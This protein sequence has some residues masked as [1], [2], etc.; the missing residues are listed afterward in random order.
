MADAT[1]TN[2]GW[3]PYGSADDSVVWRHPL[4]SALSS[5]DITGVW[6]TLT[7][8]GSGNTPTHDPILGMLC[9]DSAGA[10]A[11]Y[12]FQTIAS[13]LDTAL[14]MGGQISIECQRDL[15]CINDPTNGSSGWTPAA[16]S[17]LLGLVPSTG[18]ACVLGQKNTDGTFKFKMSAAF[19]SNDFTCGY[20]SGEGISAPKIH[21]AGKGA[22]VT[23][24]IGWTPGVAG[25]LLFVA[26]DGLLVAYGL[27]AEATTAKLFENLYIGSN[28]GS[29]GTFIAGAYFRNLQISTRPPVFPVHPRC[30]SIAFIGDSLN[31]DPINQPTPGTPAY[32]CVA[33]AQVMKYFHQRGFITGNRNSSQNPGYTIS[34]NGGSTKL[35]TVLTSFTIGTPGSMLSAVGATP[36]WKPDV[37][38]IVGGTND[39]IANASTYVGSTFT[40]SYTDLIEQIMF[41]AA[42]TTRTPTKMVFCCIPPPNSAMLTD[43]NVQTALPDVIARI[44]ALPAWWDSTYGATWGA[45]L[46]KVIDI[47]NG[48]FGANNRW[49]STTGLTVDGT[50]YD[51]LGNMLAGQY[52]A[53]TIFA[54]LT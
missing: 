21:S 20:R 7:K 38:V 51:Y 29:A 10:A 46:V 14:T 23:V 53:K 6:S 8:V 34:G 4:T 54:A 12:R 5:S 3:L 17:T 49:A 35:V 32:D 16:N 50:H 44:N 37:A 19:A 1:N 43:V 47:Y 24:N 22:F 9:L 42:K 2:Q 31:D 28:A 39:C 41:G 52:M 36:P 25:G 11:G 33:W 40:S 45:G 13:P 48:A 26:V 15:V 18:S 27:R 30:R